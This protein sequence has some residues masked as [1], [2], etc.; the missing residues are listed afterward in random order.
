MSISLSNVNPSASEKARLRA[1]SV[2]RTMVWRKLGMA[3]ILPA[4][5]PSG[6]NE[7]RGRREG[8]ARALDVERLE[9]RVDA[10]EARLGSRLDAV[11]HG[12]VPLLG[13]RE[14]H[15]LRQLRLPAEVLE[16]ERLQMVLEGLDEPLRRNDLAELAFDDAV[17]CAEAP[18]SAGAHV[19]LLDDG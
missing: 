9:H 19:H 15:R 13:R 7:R 16:L 4:A 10:L 14:V 3:W 18:A 2:M 5:P 1:G 6:T 12:R 8:S 17:R 11:L